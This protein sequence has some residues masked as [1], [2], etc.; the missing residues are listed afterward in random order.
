LT[1]TARNDKK[2]VSSDEEWRTG[3]E[4]AG[5][6]GADVKG[7]AVKEAL[8]VALLTAIATG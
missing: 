2:Y 8:V 4:K 7:R 1:R 5:G 3:V 6:K